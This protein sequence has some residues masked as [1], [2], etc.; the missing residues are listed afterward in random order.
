MPKMQFK[1]NAKPSLYAYPTPMREEKEKE[2]AKVGIK[3]NAVI[4]FTCNGHQVSTAI[5]SVTAKAQAKS[6]KKEESATPVEPM[7]V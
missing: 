6:K 2:K 7:E 4:K 3:I 5:L 1:S